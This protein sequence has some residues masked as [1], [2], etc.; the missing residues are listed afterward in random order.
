MN[1]GTSEGASRRERLRAEFTADIKRVAREQ[2]NEDGLHGVTLR[3]IARRLGVAPAG[4]YRYFD[5]LEALIEALNCDIYDDLIAGA[6]REME[7][8]GEG[9]F[10]R[11]RAWVM[12]YRAWAVGNPREFELTLYSGGATHSPIHTFH[13]HLRNPVE[14]LSPAAL[15]AM[16]HARL[17][18][19]ELGELWRERSEEFD[20]VPMPEMSEAL[21]EEVARTCGAFI[22]GEGV[23]AEMSYR[24]MSGWTRVFGLI[25]ME[26]HQMLPI[27][28]EVDEFYRVELA[29][30]LAGFGLDTS[31]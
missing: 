26:V 1:S 31:V 11:M 7:A 6:R 9:R 5:S 8:A 27:R 29:S 3:G 22:V 14:E 12:N 25:A 18:G 15:K 20:P 2:L 30:I 10:E 17:C 16:E 28:D 21:L 4:L 24:F 19:G 23:P 13:T